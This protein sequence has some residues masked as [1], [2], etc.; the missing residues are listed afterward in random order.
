MRIDDG[1]GRYQKGGIFKILQEFKQSQ[2]L[3]LKPLEI[4]T[5]TDKTQNTGS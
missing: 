4:I 1:K 5:V 2:R 3:T